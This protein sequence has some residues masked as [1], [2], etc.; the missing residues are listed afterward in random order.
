MNSYLDQCFI[1][2]NVTENM[3]GKPFTYGYISVL[4]MRIDDVPRANNGDVIGVLLDMVEGTMTF[5]INGYRLTKGITHPRLKR[6]P[7]YPVVA[8]DSFRKLRL[9]RP[10]MSTCKRHKDFSLLHYCAQCNITICD[11]CTERA[12]EGKPGTSCPHDPVTHTRSKLACHKY[13]AQ[14]MKIKEEAG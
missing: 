6:G 7:F 8:L 12:T 14:L 3:L 1:Y 10:S 4:G 5:E 9:L 11:K 13:F 2:A